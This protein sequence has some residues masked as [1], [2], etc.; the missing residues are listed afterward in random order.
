MDNNCQYFE[1]QNTGSSLEQFCALLVI[2]EIFRNSGNSK[3]NFS[4]NGHVLSNLAIWDIFPTQFQSQSSILH[5]KYV[6]SGFFGIPQKILEF[7]MEFENIVL[8]YD[9]GYQFHSNSSTEFKSIAQNVIYAQLKKFEI[10]LNSE[11]MIKTNHL[12]QEGLLYLI[13]KP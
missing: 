12:G 9:T 4:R 6:N 11:L 13:L 5:S 3:W 2:Y 7:I 8:G 1:K 10:N